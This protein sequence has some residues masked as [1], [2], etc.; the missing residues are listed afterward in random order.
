MNLT[1]AQYLAHE[2]RMKAGK[3][4]PAG[5]GCDD[6]SKLH[7][8]IIDECKRRG[9]IYLHG[10]MAHRAMRT[11][12]EPDFTILADGGQV[13]FCEC[14]SKTGKLSSE[15]L[16]LKLWA[17]KNGHTIHTIRS[18]REFLEVVA[19]LAAAPGPVVDPRVGKLTPEDA[20]MLK[21]LAEDMGAL[22]CM[23]AWMRAEIE[24]KNKPPNVNC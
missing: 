16:G 15:Q 10:S 18:F 17:K 11:P 13:V 21:K 1:L 6:E 14:K 20:A 23:P 2:A 3:N 7:D 5:A 12:G 19:G 8:A 24:T 22:D 9:W 4:E